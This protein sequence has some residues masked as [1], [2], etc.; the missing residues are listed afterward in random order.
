MFF[1]R[2]TISGFAVGFFGGDITAQD[3]FQWDGTLQAEQVGS[4][5]SPECEYVGKL[6]S[7][8]TIRQVR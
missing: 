7:G 4:A 1:R 8:N 5:L 6:S 2:Y 3:L